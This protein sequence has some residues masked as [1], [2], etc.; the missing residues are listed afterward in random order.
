MANIEVVKYADR[1]Y[2][3]CGL[4]NK[5]RYFIMI[6]NKGTTGVTNVKV[7]DSLSE[8]LRF[9]PGSMNINGCQQNYLGIG[10]PISVGNIAPGGN[11]IVSFEAEVL[12]CPDIN[13]VTNQAT[14]TYTDEIGNVVTVMS[15]VV[16]L[17]VIRINVCMKKTIGKSQVIIGEVVSYSIMIR[18]QSN[19]DIDQVIFVDDVASS[20]QVLPGTV[21]VNGIP[22]YTTDLSQGINL[23][24]L[25]AKSSIVVTFQAEVISY[26]TG[27]IITN[28]AKVDYDYTIMQ[29]STPVTSIGTS[30]SNLVGLKV[31]NK[32]INC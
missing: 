6:S 28:C 24:T 27:G 29:G 32:T 8:G 13:E 22:K 14:V 31:L 19:I 3:F 7:T 1:E 15:N 12:A 16:T 21:M 10:Y 11:T 2:I 26:P 18:N 25:T 30:C 4:S 23:G 5:V 20:L 9:V 17:P